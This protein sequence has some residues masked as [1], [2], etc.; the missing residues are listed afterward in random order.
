MSHCF[1]HVKGEVV[2]HDLA[3][4]VLTVL[5]EWG[6]GRGCCRGRAEG[7]IPARSRRQAVGAGG[8]SPRPLRLR[9]LAQKKCEYI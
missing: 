2:V 8:G 9:H 1:Y 4:W 5:R 3:C 6:K 7:M